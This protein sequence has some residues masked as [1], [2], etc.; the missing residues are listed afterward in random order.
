[1]LANWNVNEVADPQKQQEELKAKMNFTYV[2]HGPKATGFFAKEF[3]RKPGLYVRGPAPPAATTCRWM[4]G[5]RRPASA[6]T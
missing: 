6:A 5:A 1:M 3:K 2:G 4:P